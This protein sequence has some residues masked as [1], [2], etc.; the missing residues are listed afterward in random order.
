M[1]LKSI[2]I[3]GFKSFANKIEF[4]FQDGIT[5][6]VGP[7]GSG[8][9][10]VADAVRWVLGEQ[11]AKELR[12]SSM[13]DVIFSGTETRNPMGYAHVAIT[14]DNSDHALNVDY[15]EVTVARR[16]Y[17]SGE[18]EYL[19]NGNIC[20]LKDI[21][22]LF[23][24]TGIGQEGYS[25]IGQGQIDKILSGRAEE[26]RE[27]FDEAAGIVKFKRR[28]ATTQKKLQDEKNNLIRVNDILSELEKQLEPLRKQSETARIYLQKKEVLKNLDINVFLLETDR[29]DAELLE[30]EKK[31]QI[32]AGDLAK[33]T[34]EFDENKRLYEEAGQEL[35]ALDGDIDAKK[36]EI[37]NTIVFKGQIEGKINVLKEQINSLKNSDGHF[38]KRIED[39]TSQLSQYEDSLKQKLERKAVLDES[40]MRGENEA[41]CS[42]EELEE[43]EKAVRGLN[44]EI[45]ENKNA[46]LTLVNERGNIIANQQRYKTMLD[47]ANIRRSELS[48]RLIRTKSDEAELDEE[49]DKGVQELDGIN[50]QIGELEDRL[51]RASQDAE[52]SKKALEKGNRE[53]HSLEIQ[54][55]EKKSRLDSLKNMAERYEGYGSAVK[56]AMEQRNRERGIAGVVADL[57]QVEERYETAIETA[58]GGSLQNIVTRDEETAKRLISFLKENKAGRATFLPLNA[59]VARE[60]SIPEALREPGV[61]GSGDRLVKCEKQY[62]KVAK[63]LLG[64]FLVVD[65]IDNALK[66]ARKY[67][68]RLRIVTLQGDALNPG[69]SLSG[70]S[71]RNQGGLLGRSREID[72]MT[73]EMKAVLKQIDDCLSGVEEAQRRS[74]ECAREIEKI[75]EEMQESELKRNSCALNLRTLEDRKSEINQGNGG[76]LKEDNE[77]VIQIKDIQSQLERI[78]AEL[79]ESKEEEKELTAKADTLTISLEK[80]NSFVKELSDEISEVEK[81]NASIISEKKFGDQEIDRLRNYIANAIAEKEQNE[82]NIQEG[83]KELRLKEE[84]I[85]SLE[86]EIQN[87]GTDNDSREQELDIL[88]HRKEEKERERDAI[89]GS[90]DALSDRKSA[91]EREIYRLVSQKEKMES[92][93]DSLAS[94]MWNEY[95]LTRGAAEELKDPEMDDLAGMKREAGTVKSELK[96]L[97]NVNVNA[98]EEYK[99]LFDRFTFMDGQRNDL[100]KAE[101]DLNQI[102]KELDIN[103]K[104]QFSEKFAEIAKQYDSVFKELFGGGKGTLSL[105]DPERLLETDIRIIA[106]PP[107]KKLQNML[108]LSGGEKALSAIALLFAIQ[109]LKPSPFCLLDEIEAALDEA[110]VD[111]FANYLSKL[112]NHTQFI[113]ITHRRGTMMK[114]DRLYGV[115]MQEKGV[116]T[117]VSVDLA[118]DE[119]K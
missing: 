34:E 28:K 89:V 32:A 47:N 13:Q 96:G 57:I 66:I 75:K 82:R 110:N 90:R 51:N 60:I 103:M 67:K 84:S 80:K 61:I 4:K 49:I 29:I 22:E 46:V 8:K 102:I 92:D 71:F 39:L 95:E 98:I 113:V 72:S 42:R 116:S 37:S 70:G 14:L 41:S 30:N 76:I 7:N 36:T 10:N 118:S 83:D 2:E 100:V 6:I 69:G 87:Y 101:E 52:E 59:I 35:K 119:Y 106:Q 25:I 79:D 5:G 63:H 112:T 53:H 74:R 45:A 93:E 31:R 24:D 85:R 19:M 81:K 64:G 55:H 12:G 3:Q 54:Y 58:L 15:N 109:A 68:Y 26:R 107:G 18:S 38:R 97:G 99:E 104:K 73:K 48:A 11:S 56:R 78:Q 20:R 86:E 77:I 17:R 105:V 9:S 21:S 91:I 65:Q 114:A 43:A 27:L 40:V 1:Y 117:Q 16:V 50:A 62:E 23:Y 94:Y 88:I 115:T 108:Q 33:A 44:E 111:R